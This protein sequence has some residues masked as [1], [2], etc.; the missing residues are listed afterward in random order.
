MTYSFSISSTYSNSYSK[1]VT[2][3]ATLKG[4]LSIENPY[5]DSM[6][7]IIMDCWVYNNG[8]YKNGIGINPVLNVV[9]QQIGI[10]N[11]DYISDDFNILSKK[12]IL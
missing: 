8:I 11:L 5:V 10:A 12:Y 4:I 3:F 6:L 9:I 1:K 2:L 7:K